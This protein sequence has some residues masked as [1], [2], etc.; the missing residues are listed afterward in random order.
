MT[1][2]PGSSVLLLSFDLDRTR[3]ELG[4]RQQK[5]LEHAAR[6]LRLLT[7]EHQI[8][9][10]WSARNPAASSEIAALA[11]EP[12]QH[13]VA[14]ACGALAA[15]SRS[16]RSRLAQQ[17]TSARVAG[18]AISTLALDR[19]ANVANLDIQD[20]RKLGFSAIRSLPSASHNPHSGLFARLVSGFS[21]QRSALPRPTKLRFGLWDLPAT[22]VHPRQGRAGG[23]TT[24]TSPRRS[25]DRLIRHGSYLHVAIDVALVA[26]MGATRLRPIEQLLQ[27]AGQASLA[28]ALRIETIRS[29]TACL[30]PVRTTAPAQSILKRRAA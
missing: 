13:E 24:L 11:A 10:T 19:G 8:P 17:L 27:T 29:L 7:R 22:I 1:N 15:G 6:M 3:S 5:N 14:I 30:M 16:L 26:E 25:I 9:A 2:R 4:I 18:L 28:G 20:A 21:R 23:L 12:V